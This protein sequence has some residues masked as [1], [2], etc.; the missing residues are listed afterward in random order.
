[1]GI[2]QLMNRPLL[3]LSVKCRKEKALR[4]TA[5]KLKEGEKKKKMAKVLKAGT[6]VW[7]VRQL[8]KRYSITSLRETTPRLA[9]KPTKKRKK[10]QPGGI[11]E[12]L[13]GVP[14]KK[15]ALRDDDLAIVSLCQSG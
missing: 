11:E 13:K 6:V 15:R 9:L 5:T 7:V 10:T 4:P 8:T 3:S 14:R 1:L 12:G 2:I